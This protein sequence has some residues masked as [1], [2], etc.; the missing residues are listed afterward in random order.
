MNRR[1]H[2]QSGE[3]RSHDTGQ[4]DEGRKS[5]R[6]RHNQQHQGKICGF[7]ISDFS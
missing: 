2:R 3:K 1:V 7:F 5:R 6:D 4:V